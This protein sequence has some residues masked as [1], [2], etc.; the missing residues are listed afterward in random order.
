MLILVSP[1]V[2]IQVFIVF[3]WLET[4]N[5]FGNYDGSVWCWCTRCSC[6]C[7][8]NDVDVTVGIQ[9]MVWVSVYISDEPLVATA[10]S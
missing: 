4:R 1:I 10:L 5:I 8:K 3:V 7:K 6:N 2:Y 9:A